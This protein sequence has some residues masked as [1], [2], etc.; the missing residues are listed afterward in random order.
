MHPLG[1]SSAEQ[2]TGIQ[3]TVN[4]HA[5]EVKTLASHADVDQHAGPEISDPIVEPSGKPSEPTKLPSI[6]TFT[7]YSGLGGTY[8][9]LKNIYHILF[10]HQ[11]IQTK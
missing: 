6:M 2:E 5:E 1:P 10:L 8:V 11:H 7:G 3:E 4:P 9:M